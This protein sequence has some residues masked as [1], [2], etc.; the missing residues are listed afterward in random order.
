L[1][2]FQSAVPTKAE[3]DNELAKLFTEKLRKM[4]RLSVIGR[5]VYRRAEPT[6]PPNSAN[7]GY[8]VVSKVMFDKFYYLR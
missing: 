3:V 4:R 2:C 6:P 5:G 7:V 8:T 1:V